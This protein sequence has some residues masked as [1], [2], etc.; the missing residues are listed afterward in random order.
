MVCVSVLVLAYAFQTHDFRIRYIA[1]YS[2]RSMSPGFLVTSLWGG[3]DGSLLWWGFLLGLFAAACIR[4]MRGRF[5]ELQPWVIA[6]LMA[7]LLFF[8]ILMLFAANPFD[9]YP[10]SSPLEGE[11]LNPMLQSYWMSIHPP[12]LYLGFV[13]WSVPFSLAIAALITGRLHDEWVKAARVW[14]M[15]AWIFLSIGL[16]L[17]CAWSYEELGWGGYWAWDP[18]ENA[19]FMPWLVGTAYLHSAM[20]QERYSML[21]VWNVFLI[22]LTY[23]MTIF[24]TF[25]TR[26]G[27]IASVHAFARSE[28]GV[29]F[30]WFMA[31]I[32]ITC[33]ALILWRL[34][35]LRSEH[36]IQ[37][38]LSR[39]FF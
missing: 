25:L 33:T 27:M 7:N 4:W 12:A 22:C 15:I 18:V 21:K 38:L 31:L 26:S 9:V 10:A 13:G 3:Q 23:F 2:D 8:H 29:Y 11:G 6:T 14:T 37:A 16:V 20:V 30:V 19:S 17:G 32:A 35:K 24:G 39:E 34:P 36:R 28:I 1:R 5:M